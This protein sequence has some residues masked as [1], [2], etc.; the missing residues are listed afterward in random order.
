MLAVRLAQ[1]C[2]PGSGIRVEVLDGL[3]RMLND[4]ALP[5]VLE[6]GTIGTG[7]L[8]ALAGTALT[9]MGERPASRSL[10]AMSPWGS[11]NAL[12]FM[13]S[14]ALTIGRACLILDEL[15][16][17]MHS[18]LAIYSLSFVALDA[19]PSPFSHAAVVASVTPGMSEVAARLRDLIGVPRSPGR[20]QDPFG[21]RAFPI[22]FS[23]VWSAATRMREQVA[24]LLNV[25]QENP[26]F[27][28]D[29][30]GGVVHHAGFYQSALALATDGLS[31]ALAQTGPIALSRIRMMN[32][33]DVTGK[34]AFL[35]EGPAGA[36]GLLM[37]EYIAASALV[38]MRQAA[39]PASLNTVSLSRGTEEDATFAPRAVLQLEQSVAAFQVMLACELV[40]TTRLLRQRGLSSAEM[41]TDLLAH[42]ATVAFR[43]PDAV[44]DRSLRD[45]LQQAQ[46]LLPEIAV[47][48]G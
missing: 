11:E 21:L 6:S 47:L 44:H 5:S 45:D 4:D 41:P 3:S 20:I 13:S 40:E 22:N 1:L 19:N 15:K 39:Q 29:G 24:S 28:F 26:L 23:G 17:L 32:E 36:S 33:P 7:D 14:S 43:L 27:V 10:E 12:P 16:D 25:A 2:V 8:A 42:V 18:M 48:S 37:L 46:G 9:L 31:L 35:A 30:D 34:R 38:D